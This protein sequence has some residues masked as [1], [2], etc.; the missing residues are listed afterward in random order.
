MKFTFRKLSALLLA[1]MLVC[2]LGANAFAATN[3]AYDPTLFVRD[4]EVGESVVS[5]TVSI[6]L[7]EAS[8]MVFVDDGH[9]PGNL[10]YASIDYLSYMKETST[11]VVE[12]LWDQD[13]YGRIIHS[14]YSGHY[15][16]AEKVFTEE[17]KEEH[18]IAG[19]RIAG[20]SFKAGIVSAGI[21]EVGPKYVSLP[22]ET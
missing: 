8:G 16:N 1:L 17:E 14:T 2:S 11:G 10:R 5:V 6:E 18:S 20:A 12:A 13:A 21:F 7:N 19:M 3:D 22:Y 9:N 15:A 4:Y